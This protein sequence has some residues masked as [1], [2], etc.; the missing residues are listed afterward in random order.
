VFVNSRK[1][2]Q[3]QAERDFEFFLSPSLFLFGELSQN[4]PE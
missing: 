3:V 2:E 1:E 4:E